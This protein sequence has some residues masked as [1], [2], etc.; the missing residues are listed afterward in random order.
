MRLLINNNLLLVGGTAQYDF[1]PAADYRLSQFALIHREGKHPVLK[2]PGSDA[3]TVHHPAIIMMVQELPDLQYTYDFFSPD[4]C[5]RIIEYLAQVGILVC[6]E[7]DSTW[8]F[9]N[10]LFLHETR[11][12]S[13]QQVEAQPNPNLPVVKPPMSDEI[14]P[15]SVPSTTLQI[16]LDD[17]RS[18]RVFSDMT[19]EQVGDFLWHSAR[20]KKM[21]LG[22]AYDASLRPYPGAGAAYELEIYPII[23]SKL[24]HYD[25]LHHHLE[26]LN[27]NPKNINALLQDAAVHMQSAPPP[28]LLIVTAR[29]GRIQWKY[30]HTALSLILKD[31]GA[32]FQTWY[33]VAAAMELAACA[34]GGG[35]MNLFADTIGFPLQDEASVG[36][37]AIGNS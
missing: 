6:H 29:F 22:E 21:V 23:N 20:V 15:L 10:W 37:F 36:E 31:V 8:A 4:T 17:R 7:E 11:Q 19:L 35:N 28:V 24:F 30:P 1:D 34:I 18:S 5:M 12:G 33:L 26:K 27:A 14:L 16:S 3:I 32:L 9:H 13:Y 2:I 25:P